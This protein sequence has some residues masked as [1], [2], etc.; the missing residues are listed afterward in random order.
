[1]QWLHRFW[2]I[3]ELFTDFGPTL[4]WIFLANFKDFVPA[5]KV[6]MCKGR[7]PL[8]HAAISSFGFNPFC[9]EKW[10]RHKNGFI[11]PFSTVTSDRANG[12]ASFFFWP[13]VWKLCSKNAITGAH[14]ENGPNSDLNQQNFGL[15]KRIRFNITVFRLLVRFQ[16]L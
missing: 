4:A 1:M 12:I 13:I 3:S 11:K 9:L 10:L 15:K 7:F 16:S 2:K 6:G 14:V 8:V 5:D